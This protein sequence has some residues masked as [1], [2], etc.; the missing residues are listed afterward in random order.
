MKKNLLTRGMAIARLGMKAHSFKKNEDETVREAARS[1]L[2]QQ[3]GQLKGLPQKV[4]QIISMSASE[5]E[6][7][8]F[9]KL[10]N[11]GEA[12]PLSVI[13][14][15]LETA[16]RCSPFDVLES[17]EETGMA[18]SLGQVHRAFLKDG[19]EVAVKIRYP[20]IRD[21]VHNDLKMLGWLSAPFGGMKKFD[22]EEY[23]R[24]F[25]ETLNQEMDYL[26]ECQQQKQFYQLSKNSRIYSW[27]VP[28]VIDAWC[29]D[30][31]L[32]TSWE[33]GEDIHAVCQNWSREEKKQLQTIIA[34]I[35]F[36]CV[37]DAGVF[38]ADPHPGNYAFRKRDGRV[39]VVMYD[40][41][42][43][44][45]VSTEARMAILKLYEGVCVQGKYSPY[46]WYVYLGFNETYLEPIAPKIPWFTEVLMEPFACEIKFDL[47]RW[48]RTARIAE[49]MADDRWNIRIAAPPSILL[50]MRGFAGLFYYLERLGPE[51]WLYP[52][53]QDLLKQFEK[54]LLDTIPPAVR[55]QPVYDD[56][57]RWLKIKVTEYGA[58]KVQITMKR[59]AVEDLAELLPQDI[60]Q[61]VRDQNIDLSH[62]VA[63]ARANIFR[64]GDI[65][66]MEIPERHKLIRVWLE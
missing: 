22:M 37:F 65:F 29:T 19:R 15:L 48:N 44:A 1:Y 57:A 7:P 42:C 24:V 64:P 61:K 31:V 34:D 43:V 62:L 28:E 50:M 39:E 53:M 18:A 52:Y 47:S 30:Q 17:I 45:T 8:Q 25:S 9:M 46:P 66:I 2:V 13:L 35:F 27:I 21:A 16:W 32:M 14:E 5:K 63:E 38:H 56:M 41:G 51:M 33:Q 49:M 55:L 54:E 3:M 12:L 60:A 6:D 10:V 4:G 40:F 11:Q 59:S 36:K 26:R 23:Q 20:G 58:T